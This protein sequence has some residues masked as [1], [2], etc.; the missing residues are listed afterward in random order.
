MEQSHENRK[1]DTGK[2]E[3]GNSVW[4]EKRRAGGGGV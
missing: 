4:E 3:S 2:I 1:G